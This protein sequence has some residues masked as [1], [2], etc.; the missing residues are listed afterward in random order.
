M[1]PELLNPTANHPRGAPP[2]DVFSFG[3]MLWEC[4]ARTSP[5]HGMSFFR[6]CML[7]VVKQIKLPFHP[8]WPEDIKELLTRYV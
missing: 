3:V 8:E 1:A 7:I 6:V 4:L 5:W 2:V